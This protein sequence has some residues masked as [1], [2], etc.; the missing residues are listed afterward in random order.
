MAL[1]LKLY[2]QFLRRRRFHL[3]DNPF[4]SNFPRETKAVARG[5][6]TKML[7]PGDLQKWES[8]WKDEPRPT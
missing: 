5:E 3:P 6:D 8:D 2:F 4:V 1:I 7:F